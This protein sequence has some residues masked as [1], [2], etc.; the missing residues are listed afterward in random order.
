MTG[1]ADKPTVLVVDDDEVFRTRLGRALGERGFAVTLAASVAEAL[2]MAEEAP[3]F[4]VVD[5]RMPGQSGMELL[6]ALKAKDPNTRVVMLTGYGSIPTAIEATKLG[7][8]G[9]LTK[10]ADADDVVKALLGEQVTNV[11]ARETPT[12]ARAEWEYI[13]RV[14][15]DCGDN[16]SEAARRLGIHRR[17]LQRKLQKYPPAT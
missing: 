14:L 4:A 6:K 17:S 9:Y 13:H 2:A 15:A 1:E 7:A 8:A 5:L 3:E 10:P 16:I 12:L 11:A